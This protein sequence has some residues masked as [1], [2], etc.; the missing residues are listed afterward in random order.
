MSKKYQYLAKKR[1]SYRY[2]EAKTMCIQHGGFQTHINY[3]TCWRCLRFSGS[4]RRKQQEFD[5][6]NGKCD[7]I[8]VVEPFCKILRSGKWFFE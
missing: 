6:K 2:Q 4:T 8:I 1:D 5:L 7:K 3:T